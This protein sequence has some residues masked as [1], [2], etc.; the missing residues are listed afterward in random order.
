MS[1]LGLTRKTAADWTGDGIEADRLN[2]IGGS[3]SDCLFYLPP[4][5]WLGDVTAVVVRRF[6]MDRAVVPAALRAVMAL[7]RF[8]DRVVAGGA[9]GA[10]VV[11]VCGIA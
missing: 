1:M 8:F 7:V 5:S 10:L 11:V 6:G 4:L 3:L 9:V 2:A